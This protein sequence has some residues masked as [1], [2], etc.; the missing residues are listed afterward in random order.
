MVLFGVDQ[1]R[2]QLNEGTLWAGGPYDPSSPDALNAFPEARRHIFDGKYGD[3]HPF[4]GAKMMA[5]PLQQMAYETVGDL[6]LSFPRNGYVSGYRRELDLETGIAQVSY[7]IHINTEIDGKFGGCSGIVEMLLQSH[8]GEIDLL[9]ALP[10][11]WPTGTVKTKRIRTPNIEHPTPNVEQ[12]RRKEQ[13]EGVF[14]LS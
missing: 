12:K 1:E 10:K 9:P 2:L 13:P 7:T 14:F 5:R 4:I 3:A 11:V 8:A 6:K